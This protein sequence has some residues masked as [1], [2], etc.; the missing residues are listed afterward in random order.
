MK[1]ENKTHKMPTAPI[2][3]ADT[4]WSGLPPFQESIGRHSSFLS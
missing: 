3:Q 2:K 1:K 4:T